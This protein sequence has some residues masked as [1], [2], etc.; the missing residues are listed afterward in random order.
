MILV[1]HIPW[2]AN[3]INRRGKNKNECS[4]FLMVIIYNYLE[5]RLQKSN[6]LSKVCQ[7]SL[8]LQKKIIK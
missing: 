7:W 3:E 5:L 8:V 2:K 4:I 1:F 6:K